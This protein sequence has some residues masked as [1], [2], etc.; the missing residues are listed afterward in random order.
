MRGKCRRLAYCTE[1][2]S[3]RMDQFAWTRIWCVLAYAWYFDG[4]KY[5][6]AGNA[7]AY[8]I[9]VPIL[10]ILFSAVWLNE[11]VDSSL[12]IGGILAVSG[13]GIMHW[14]RRLIK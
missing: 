6:G 2:I 14:G 1:F 4:V 8:I 13:L 5:L 9:L 12:I 10:G 3:R 7:S 11:Q